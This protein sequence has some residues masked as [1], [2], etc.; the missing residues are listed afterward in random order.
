MYAL[1]FPIR[2]VHVRDSQDTR[3]AN[4]SNTLGFVDHLQF[5]RVTVHGDQA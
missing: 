4:E 1:A 2:H 5:T 3:R